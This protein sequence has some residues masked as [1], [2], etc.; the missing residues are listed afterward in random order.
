[1]SPLFDMRSTHPSSL[2]NFLFLPQ[3]VCFDANSCIMNMLIGNALRCVFGEKVKNMWSVQYKLLNQRRKILNVTAWYERGTFLLILRLYSRAKNTFVLR[4]KAETQ[5]CFILPVR[6]H[7]DCAGTL[8]VWPNAMDSPLV[9]DIQAV[10]ALGSPAVC[11]WLT[12]ASTT[13]RNLRGMTRQL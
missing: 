2:P 1:M 7:R 11:P 5:M 10:L 8:N 4:P 6:I 9:A 3:D 12:K 13:C